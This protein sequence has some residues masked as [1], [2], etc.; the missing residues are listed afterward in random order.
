M[1]GLITVPW[2]AL[3]SS[4]CF[5][6][7]LCPDGVVLPAANTASLA[8]VYLCWTSLNLSYLR[9]DHSGLKSSWT[10]PVGLHAF[11]KLHPG[12]TIL[13]HMWVDTTATVHRWPFPGIHVL[14]GWGTL[15]FSVSELCP[16]KFS[17]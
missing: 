11:Q 17:P 6:L 16:Q 3:P 5:T 2:R 9:L 13:H 7:M 15:F 14:L 4:G 12:S 1:M 10:N 8:V